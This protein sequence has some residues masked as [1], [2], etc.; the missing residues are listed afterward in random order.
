M[1][2]DTNTRWFVVR[3]AAKHVGQS[4]SWSLQ[5]RMRVAKKRKLFL[6]FIADFHF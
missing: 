1:V 3:D 4:F 5:I 6:S 2:D